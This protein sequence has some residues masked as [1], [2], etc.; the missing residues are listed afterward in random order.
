MENN[1]GTIIFQENP[2]K[3]N[4]NEFNKFKGVWALFGKSK[5]DD[6]KY[7]CL[8]VG[9]SADIK[10]EVEYDIEKFKLSIKKDGEKE[11][12]N[13]FGESCGLRYNSGNTQEYLYPFL[14]KRYKD[15]IFVLINNKSNDPMFE[16]KFAW[17]THACYWRNGRPFSKAQKNYYEKHVNSIIENI[18][19]EENNKDIQEWMIFI[20]KFNNSQ[21]PEDK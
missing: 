7:I 20:K 10:S 21:N 12:I 6:S 16:R 15:F 3:N 5:K 13:Q 1:V 18:S 9:K 8:N 14:S 11:Y 2:M 19:P 4:L 17:A